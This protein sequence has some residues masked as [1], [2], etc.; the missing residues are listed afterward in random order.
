MGWQQGYS[1]VVQGV[2]Q[3]DIWRVW[4][5]VNNW[6]RWDTDIDFAKL[7][8]PFQS[9]ASFV[10]KPKGGPQFKLEFTE[11]VPFVSYTDF[12]K[13]PFA[14]MYGIHTMKPTDDGLELECRIRIEG[15]LGFVWR[16]IVGEGVVR[17]LK[18]QTEQMV[19]Y[20]KKNR[21]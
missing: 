5:D 9:G 10:L 18:K 13:F 7:E 3:E 6:H 17:G 19:A 11:I 8:G 4:Q 12:T 14:K 15:P 16:K 20:A 21:A 1:V 2:R